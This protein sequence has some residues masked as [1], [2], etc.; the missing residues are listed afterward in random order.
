MDAWS[1]WSFVLAKIAQG[2]QPSREHLA[3]L[4]TDPGI[5]EDATAEQ[6]E[7]L[8]RIVR[9]G[10]GARPMREPECWPMCGPFTVAQTLALV[11]VLWLWGAL[12]YYETQEPG[13]RGAREW[14]RT[15]RLADLFDPMDLED[16]WGD[17]CIPDGEAE[18]CLRKVLVRDEWVVKEPKDQAREIVGRF[19]NVSPDA[20]REWERQLSHRDFWIGPAF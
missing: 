16:M 11:D 13:P 5:P 7:A 20:L 12:E 8:A 19:H 1:E 15:M 3:R 10:P 2:K 6:R 18:V 4:L 14:R 9:E 17:S